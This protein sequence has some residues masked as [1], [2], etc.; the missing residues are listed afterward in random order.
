MGM[1]DYDPGIISAYIDLCNEALEGQS[2]AAKGWPN[3]LILPEPENR[4]ERKAVD[5][6]MDELNTAT[7]SKVIVRFQRRR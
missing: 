4:H 3:P 7:A 2:K 5:L 6:F 1:T